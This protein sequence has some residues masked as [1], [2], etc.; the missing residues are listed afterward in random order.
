MQ[1]PATRYRK[2]EATAPF[3]TRTIPIGASM[4][5]WSKS[6]LGGHAMR[7]MGRQLEGTRSCHSPHNYDLLL[8]MDGHIR[9]KQGPELHPR[10]CPLHL[11]QSLRR[12]GIHR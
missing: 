7:P 10:C 4:F 3:I 2:D 9:E 12:C 11:W 5:L 1:I 8:G 6:G